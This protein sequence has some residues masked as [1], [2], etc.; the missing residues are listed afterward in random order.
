MEINLS[1]KIA[2]IFYP[3]HKA[4]RNQTHDEFWLH[5]GRGST[6]SSFT[7]T[8]II[9]GILE[10]S[11]VNAIAFRK[12][13]RTVR[14]SIQGSLNWA[15]DEL[16]ESENFDSIS[17]PAE[18]TYKPTGQKI[19]MRGLDE[20]RKLKSIKLRQGYFKYLWFE[21]ADEFNGAEEIRNV[22]QS[23][24]R[25]G[26]KFVEFLTYNPP[27]N[28]KHWI[29]KMVEEDKE[30]KFIHHSTYLDVPREWLGEKFFNKA[31]R[32]KN[33]NYEAYAHEYLGK[34]IGNPEE[35]VFSGKYEVRDFDTPD[36]SEMYQNRFFFGCDWGFA[37][38]KGDTLIKTN[39]G[40]KQIKD[41]KIGDLVLTREGY[42][43]VTMFMNKGFKKVYE[44]DFGLQ[45]PIIVTGDHLIYTVDGWKRADQL[46][47]TET[48]CVTKLS[49]MGR[50]IKCILKAKFLI[51]AVKLV[52]KTIKSCLFYIGISGNHFMV[53]SLKARL[54]IISMATSTIIILKIL[55]VCPSQIMQKFIIQK[56]LALFLR[57]NSQKYAKNTAT[58]KR[59]GIKGV[60]SQLKPLG[61]VSKH[62]LSVIK[63][64]QSL[65]FIKSFADLIAEKGQILE[66][67]KKNMF[68]RLVMLN[69]WLQHILKEN[70]ALK[71][72]R[73]NLRPLKEE[74]EVFDISVENSEFFAND[75]LVHNCDPTVLIRFFIQDDCLWIDYESYAT[76]VEI[77]HIGKVIFDKIP[78]SRKWMIEA[79]S[80][81]P[82]TI[83]NLRRQ[84][85]EEGKGFNIRG[86][87]KWVGCADDRIE[88]MKNFKKI[89]IHTRCPRILQEF[90][91]LSYKIDKE[92]K[93]ALPV[94]DDKKDR[95]KV[96]GDKIGIKD[97]GLDAIGYGLTTYIKK[98][99][100]NMGF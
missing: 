87:R 88:Y 69:L 28:P 5:G 53:R 66:R 76:Q 97:D 17:S 92:T 49:L 90:E 60:L 99:A 41:I 82:E 50:F 20:P 19:L 8:Q 59:I 52:A 48:I 83:S 13:S 73:I 56:I 26:E 95:I 45:T 7:A 43:T 47:E 32:L 27:R 12:V 6:K 96:N 63:K 3:V 39:K 4:I 78:E 89:I 94:I 84:I 61:S 25:G 9:L 33:N 34:S 44:L 67:V 14:D 21:E 46:K 37:C 57:K 81:R 54:Y 51:I 38:L 55:L 74:S 35:I 62:V 77:D 31:E 24:L 70:H 42:K 18:I 79:D 80:S 23:V 15:I 29:N 65:M 93:E 98:G 71:N 72:V 10:D 85:N 64:L 68:V 40:E 100:T 36:I 16:G 75:V 91:T 58:Q 2:P 1:E 30:N 86:A 11:N 22:E